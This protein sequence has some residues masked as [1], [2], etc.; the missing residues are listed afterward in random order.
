[1][2]HSV[3]SFEVYNYVCSMSGAGLCVCWA[4]VLSLVLC[5][6]GEDISLNIFWQVHLVHL[7]YL[8]V[9]V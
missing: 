2:P 9:K 8:H 5:W 3:E 6:T 4:P 7:I 1:M